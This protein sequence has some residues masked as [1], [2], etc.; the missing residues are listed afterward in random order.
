MIPFSLGANSVGLHNMQE[1]LSAAPSGRGLL[2]LNS[3]G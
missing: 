2:A 1:T 3:W